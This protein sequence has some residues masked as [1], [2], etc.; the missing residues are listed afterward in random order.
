MSHDEEQRPNG[1]PTHTPYKSSTGQKMSAF[2]DS[3]NPAKKMYME[4]KLYSNPTHL[5]RNDDQ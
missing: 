1:E 2:R 3:E 4:C 5:K